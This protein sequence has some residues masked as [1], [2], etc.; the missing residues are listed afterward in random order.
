MMLLLLD[1]ASLGQRGDTLVQLVVLYDLI[2]C[3]IGPHS[4]TLL[5]GIRVLG[6]DVIMIR[7]EHT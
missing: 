6:Q 3:G 4:I 2:L 7:S 1:F 5:L